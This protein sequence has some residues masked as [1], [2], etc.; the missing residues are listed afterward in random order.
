MSRIPAPPID[1]SGTRV[2]LLVEDNSG[3]VTLVHDLLDRVAADSLRVVHVQTLAAAVDAL[4][5]NPVDV[6]V[7]DLHLPDS[8][9]V[10][11]VRRMHGAAGDRPIIVLTG[12]DED[13]LALACIEAGGQDYL[14]KSEMHPRSLM[15]AIGYA[16]SRVQES[17]LRHLQR[18]L[19]RYRALSSATQGTP[20]TAAL[21]GS[22]AVATR[23]PEAFETAVR[24]YFTLFEPYLAQLD[25]RVDA[26][27]ADKERIVTLLG[28]AGAGPRDLLDVHVAALDRAMATFK[29][30]HGRTVVFEGRLLALEMMG[31]LVDYYRVGQRRRFASG[32]RP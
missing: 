29:D 6:I 1:E 18:L 24:A 5:T 22:G 31:L 32:D 9:G 25:D 10:E 16:I 7:L 12:S 2:L 4:Q 3:D 30:R 21:S 8:A 27:R 20:V 13:G 17:R 15:R 23:H 26:P 11:T 28:D 14:L 19:E